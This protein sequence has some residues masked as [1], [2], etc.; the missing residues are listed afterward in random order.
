MRHKAKVRSSPFPHRGPAKL[1]LS[2]TDPSRIFLDVTYR[3]N[4]RCR[5]CSVT[6]NSLAKA[7]AKEMSTAEI[8]R[9][10]AGFGSS[11][12]KISI[13][14]GEPL[15]RPDIVEIV[16]YIKARGHEC[17]L[18]TNGLLL[19]PELAGRLLAAGL[20]KLAF[21]IHG[22]AAQHEAVLGRRGFYARL[23]KIVR[24]V[25]A[26]RKKTGT[27]LYLWCT[28]NRHNYLSLEKIARS[29]AAL[30]PDRIHLNHV[31]YVSDRAAAE[32]SAFWKKN[33]KGKCRARSSQ[34]EAEG[35]DA[36]KLLS[37]IRKVKALKLR[38]LFFYPRMTSREIRAWY[39]PE[40]VIWENRACKGQWS[41]MTIA[42]DGEIISCQILDEKL[43]NIRN[44]PYLAEYRGPAF[45][46]F[47][48][49]L[50]K[51]G[52]LFPACAKCGNVWNRCGL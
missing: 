32:T 34:G 27:K 30:G 37:E 28:I 40:V 18:M 26:V 13:G 11:K 23:I 5:F 39:D 43:G 48:A 10:V 12:R 41:N 44:R 2:V 7:H 21:S 29:L 31:E 20:D 15:L 51:N 19:T 36:D 38:N 6:V 49:A 16:S 42:P 9:I 50:K 35:I 45:S 4:A 22:S 47:R 24:A 14:G 46:R 17:L 1:S 33:F 3:C 25:G 52:G 8:K